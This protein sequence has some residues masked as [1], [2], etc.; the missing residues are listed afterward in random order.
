MSDFAPPPRP[1][2][3]RAEWGL[4]LLL[5]AIQFTNI[6]DF[7]IIMPIAPWAQA[8]YGIN[9][10]QFGHIIAA[11]GFASFAGSILA[12]K[13]LDRFGRK[14]ALLTV[15]FGFTLSTLMC[16]LAPT[17]ETLVA[18][19]AITGLFGGVVG[20]AVMAIIGDVFADYRRGT[21]MGAVM[22]AFAMS[23]IF[24]L[25]LGLLLVEFFGT[26]APFVA[27][28]GLSALVWAGVFRV[29]PPLP[30]NPQRQQHKAS[31]WRLA[32][33][34]NHVIAFL[35]SVALV[36][37]SFTVVPYL[38]LSMVANSGQNKEDM[39]YLYPV[40]GAFTLISTNLVGR[41]S[42]RYGKRLLFRI[43]GVAAIV[44][45]LVLTNLPPVP[46]WLAIAAATGFMVAT[47]GRMVPAQA[48]ITASAAPQVR[49]GFLSLNSAVQSAAMGLSSLIGGTLIGQ[50]E[51][52][53]MPGYPLVGIIAAA[54]ALLSL[55]LAGF[56]KSAEGGPVR[57]EESAS[58]TPSR[59]GG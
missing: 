14:A 41:L 54:S 15:Y 10:E 56:L 27:L 21:A 18:A 8:K 11:Y 42:D 40:A 3:S 13:Y 12:A 25:P 4:L 34:P 35:F 58:S 48:M 46:L 49:G 1:A 7:V 17:Y 51:D 47:S 29:L 50:T 32:I 55:V 52:G 44:M 37:G 28:A 36:L 19:R 57:V 5:A 30:V 23:T 20:S 53:R 31:L 22:S 33:E 45:A 24:G 59:R 2:I 26:G 9:S 6:L 39:K 16:G 43:M 38:A